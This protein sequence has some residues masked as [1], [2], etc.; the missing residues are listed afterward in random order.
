MVYH[1]FDIPLHVSVASHYSFVLLS[2]TLT[3]FDS[4]F[5]TTYNALNIVLYFVTYFS[6]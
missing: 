6:F 1:C 5:D 4:M 2:L 3:Y